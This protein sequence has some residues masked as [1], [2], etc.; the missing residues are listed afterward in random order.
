VPNLRDYLLPITGKKEVSKVRYQ[1]Y[2]YDEAGKLNHANGYD[3]QGKVTVA[4]CEEI[5]RKWV[6]WRQQYL[7]ENPSL[8]EH[9]DPTIIYSYHPCGKPEKAKRLFIGEKAHLNNKKKESKKMAEPTNEERSN[10][11]VSV[12]HEYCQVLEGRV[13]DDDDGD[14]T[15]LL[16]DMMHFCEQKGFDFITCLKMAFTHYLAETDLNIIRDNDQTKVVVC[17]EGGVV[18][19]AFSTDKSIDLEVWDWD[20]KAE[21]EEDTSEILS[22]KFEKLTESMA[23]VWP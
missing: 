22:D 2:A 19:G 17:V 15:D 14:I 21:S 1:I 11:I 10:R 7:K 6:E 23:P 4:K 3:I 8:Q 16:A 9:N 13:F 5:E 18:Q 20:D 12:M